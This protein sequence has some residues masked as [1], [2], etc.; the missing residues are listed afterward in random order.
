M[1][2][3][4]WTKR[5]F[6]I[7]SLKNTIDYQTYLK[8]DLTLLAQ[9]FSSQFKIDNQ[10]IKV[11]VFGNDKIYKVGQELNLYWDIEDMIVFGRDKNEK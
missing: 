8:D 5:R 1:I 10:M 2:G 4:L 7:E 6:K 11:V 3:W 9:K